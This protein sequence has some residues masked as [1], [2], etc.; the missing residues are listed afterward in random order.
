MATRRNGKPYIY[1]TWLA[2]LLGGHQCVWSAWFKAHFRYDKYEAQASDLVQWNRDHTELMRR[3]RAELE[4]EGFT[5]AVEQENDFKID[6]AHAVIAG[7]PDIVA[8]KPGITLLVDGKTGRERESDIWQVLI[9]LWAYQKVRG[10]VAG[11]LEGEVQYKSGDTRIAVT[12][13]ELT[14]ER[15][16]QIFTLIRTVAGPTQPT[17]VPSRYECQV[18]NIGPADCPA[19]L[20]ATVEAVV[21]AT[22]F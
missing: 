19:R 9:Y 14:K 21:T 7:K 18:C 11:V 15:L 12:P 4:R 1:V 13:A 20:N 6:G 17:R 8:T 10:Q 5:V 16:D 22:E 2:K 3:R